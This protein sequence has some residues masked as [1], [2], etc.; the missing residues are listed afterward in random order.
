MHP[1]FERPHSF[2]KIA[3][4]CGFACSIKRREAQCPN[5]E[6]VRIYW[7]KRR[8]HDFVP[9]PNFQLEIRNVLRVVSD[10]PSPPSP[11]I[12]GIYDL[13]VALS[14]AAPARST[15]RHSACLLKPA[16]PTSKT[17]PLPTSIVHQPQSSAFHLNIQPNL[18]HNSSFI[19]MARTK[20][21]ARKV[22]P[23]S[24]SLSRLVA[25]VVAVNW[26]QRSAHYNLITTFL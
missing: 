25:N 6:L 21:T 26:W 5:G 15:R 18:H 20:Q 12:L 7:P 10:P 14:F 17:F 1:D 22:L 2:V 13:F 3:Q 19:A 16:T 4:S 9:S 11:I 24:S 23:S 8:F